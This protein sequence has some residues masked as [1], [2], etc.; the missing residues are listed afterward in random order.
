M[1]NGMLVIGDVPLLFK[2]CNELTKVGGK[3]ASLLQGGMDAPVWTRP[4]LH[5]NSPM[6]KRFY[7]TNCI[8]LVAHVNAVRWLK[9]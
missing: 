6:L 7:M 4:S 3:Q 9:S 5:T 8:N 2:L 1:S